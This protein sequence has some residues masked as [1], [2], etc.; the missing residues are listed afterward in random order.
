MKLA[1]SSIPSLQFGGD[2]TNHIQVSDG[3]PTMGP[4]RRIE[5]D[6]KSSVL[7]LFE[8]T[9]VRRQT[10]YSDLTWYHR[11]VTEDVFCD[12]CYS[13]GRRQT[14]VTFDARESLNHGRAQAVG[15]SSRWR[16]EFVE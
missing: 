1:Q 6:S 12:V 8:L 7:R 5:P 15:D 10:H 13:I 16:Q 11:A 4:A 9:R 3:D 2:E 14:A